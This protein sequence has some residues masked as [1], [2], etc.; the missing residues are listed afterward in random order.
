M[1]IYFKDFNYLFLDRGEGREKER[2]RNITQ[3]P[4]PCA[5]TLQTDLCPDQEW[6]QGTSALQD[7]TGQGKNSVYL[8]VYALSAQKQGAAE[9]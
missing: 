8:G 9:N 5:L 7:H 6:N 2:E 3:L 1:Y 4:L